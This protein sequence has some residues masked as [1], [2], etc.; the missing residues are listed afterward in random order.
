M[1]AAER[2]PWAVISSLEHPRRL[3]ASSMVFSQSYG[4]QL[5]AGRLV[6]RNGAP[7]ATDVAVQ[8]AGQSAGARGPPPRQGP[9]S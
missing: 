2:K 5:G 7:A 3:Q 1:L 6:G 9:P 4:A 8:E